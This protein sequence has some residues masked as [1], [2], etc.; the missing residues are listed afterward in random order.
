MQLLDPLAPV[1]AGEVLVTFGSRSGRPYAPGIPIGEIVEVS[2]TPGQLTR[3]ATVR[4]FVD[5]SSPTWWA[6]WWSRRGGPSR[7]RAAHAAA[8]PHSIG[9]RSDGQPVSRRHGRPQPHGVG[10]PDGHPRAHHERLTWTWRRALL[11]TVLLYL[12]P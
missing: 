4:P 9:H 1:E 3:V 10:R 6:S 2:G 12:P 11:A 8:E 7:R 5:V